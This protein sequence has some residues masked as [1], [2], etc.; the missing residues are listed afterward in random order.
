MKNKLVMFVTTLSIVFAVSFSVMGAQAQTESEEEHS[1][2]DESTYV[3]RDSAT[4]LLGFKTIPPN[5]FIHL[6]DTTPYH[7][8][9]G[10]VA[11]KLPCDENS[12]T[13]L[14][15]LIGAAPHLEA[16]ELELISELSMPGKSCMYHADLNSDEEVVTDIAIQNPTEKSIRFPSTSTVVIGINEI[17]PTAGSHGHDE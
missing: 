14:N 9:N 16:A 10:H 15:I 1:E 2:S 5:D 7:I 11:A 13:S 8:M 4:V 6:Y 12:E 3:V 17:M